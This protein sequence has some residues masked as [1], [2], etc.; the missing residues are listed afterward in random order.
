MTRQ[1]EK[2]NKKKSKTRS[3][4]EHIFG[5]MTNSMNGIR[6]RSIGFARA[7]FNIGLMNLTY[8]M[9]RYRFLVAQG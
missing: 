3:R 1:Q 7:E 6:I 2:D 5:F 4:I 8:N 9:S